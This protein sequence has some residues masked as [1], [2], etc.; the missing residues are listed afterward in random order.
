LG[1]SR[2]IPPFSGIAIRFMAGTLKHL[3][4]PP[5]ILIQ[6]RAAACYAERAHGCFGAPRWVR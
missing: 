5:Q 6:V 3:R 4:W 2:L 1:S